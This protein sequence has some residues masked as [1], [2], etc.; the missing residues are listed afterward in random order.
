[1]CGC[2]ASGWREF[3]VSR[4]GGFTSSWIQELLDSRVCA[5]ISSWVHEVMQCIPFI[6][7]WIHELTVAHEGVGCGGSARGWREFIM[8]ACAG[9]F[10]S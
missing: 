4:V 3:M 7:A 9:G 2:G 10:M 5:F 6:S 8:D 1:M